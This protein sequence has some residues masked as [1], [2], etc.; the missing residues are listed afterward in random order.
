MAFL[1]AEKDEISLENYLRSKLGYN[2]EAF[3]DIYKTMLMC[4][5]YPPVGSPLICE[6]DV[7]EKIAISEGLTFG[8]TILCFLCRRSGVPV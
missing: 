8:Q 3:T 6:R 4:S 7:L 5:A 1:A 2:G